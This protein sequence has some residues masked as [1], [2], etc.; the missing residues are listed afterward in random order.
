MQGGDYKHV[1]CA[2]AN[3]SHHIN[4]FI[5]KPSPRH[6]RAPY[7]AFH[8]QNA[9]HQT[10]TCYTAHIKINICFTLLHHSSAITL[11]VLLLLQVHSTNYNRYIGK[12]ISSSTPHMHTAPQTKSCCV[13]MHHRQGIPYSPQI[14]KKTTF[15]LQPQRNPRRP[16]LPLMRLFTQHHKQSRVV[17][18]CI[19]G[20]EFPIHP[21]SKKKNTHLHDKPNGIHAAH[22]CL[23]H[24]HTSTQTERC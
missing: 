20:N 19:T 8:V 1:P 9:Q 13:R 10:T 11:L 23:P 7:T 16:Y 15:T 17:C 24:M 18:V 2:P 12:N 6:S 3:G 22:K 4:S 21:R 5:N 14:Q